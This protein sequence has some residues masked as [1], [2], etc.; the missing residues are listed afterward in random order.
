MKSLLS[1]VTKDHPLNWLKTAISADSVAK[2][3]LMG[4]A[5]MG[6]S[7]D[8][9]SA[10]W[11]CL[12]QEQCAD[13]CLAVIIT[14]WDAMKSTSSQDHSDSG[15]LTNETLTSRCRALLAQ[16]V[17]LRIPPN[18]FVHSWDSPMGNLMFYNQCCTKCQSKYSVLIVLHFSQRLETNL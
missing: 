3:R 5:W 13:W 15:L 16:P 12:W 7:F 4:R 9:H 17:L 8:V 2:H 6:W 10:L 1:T 11:A 14:E 18:V